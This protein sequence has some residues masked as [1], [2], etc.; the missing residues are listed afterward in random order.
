MEE[1]QLAVADAEVSLN[2]TTVTEA[3]S[4]LVKTASE[5]SF[6]DEDESGGMVGAR[7]PSHVQQ[8]MICHKNVTDRD[9][10]NP[11]EEEPGAATKRQEG[12]R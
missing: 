12:C 3:E 6:M 1:L 10:L 8:K 5:K 11:V 2:L 7:M 4:S 9:W